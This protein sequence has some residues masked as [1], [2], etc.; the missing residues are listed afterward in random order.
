M[1]P[2]E[3]WSQMNASRLDEPTLSFFK[4]AVM[5]MSPDQLRQLLYWTTCLSALPMNGLDRKIQL[6]LSLKIDMRY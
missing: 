6:V 3:L 2:N 1:D 5:E 4:L